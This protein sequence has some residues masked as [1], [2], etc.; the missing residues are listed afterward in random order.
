[1]IVK[2]SVRN[3]MCVGRYAEMMELSEAKWNHFEMPATEMPI[4]CIPEECDT[5]NRFKQ[6]HIIQ[7]MLSHSAGM[8]I[9]CATFAGI[10]L[11]LYY[12]SLCSLRI[13]FAAYLPTHIKSLRDFFQSSLNFHRDNLYI[14]SMIFRTVYE[15]RRGEPGGS[16]LW[17]WG[18]LGFIRCF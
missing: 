9:C 13:T 4:L 15:T 10:S 2:N 3:L 18:L 5:T 1:M 12:I 17:I 6:T 8:H 7:I 16:P 14:I 11:R